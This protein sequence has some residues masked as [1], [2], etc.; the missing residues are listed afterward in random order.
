MQ[1]AY[2]N[3][4]HI[5]QPTTDCGFRCSVFL[6]RATVK[7][8]RNSQGITIMTVKQ[9]EG[10]V[11]VCVSAGKT[12]CLPA[13]HPAFHSV[14]CCQKPTRTLS[15]MYNNIKLFSPPDRTNVTTI[16]KCWCRAMTRRF[17]PAAPTPSTPPAVTIR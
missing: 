13:A 9:R 4:R 15:L 8:T 12:R 14:V 3:R 7:T 17:S 16:S 11:C 10:C 1:V 2:Q 5:H 6:P